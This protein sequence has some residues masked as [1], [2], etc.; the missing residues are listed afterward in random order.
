MP[1]V[2]LN[3]E[4]VRICSICRKDESC[5]DVVFGYDHRPRDKKKAKCDKCLAE[6]HRERRK[7]PVLNASARAACRKW[8]RNNPDKANAK[9]RRYQ[10]KD[11][12]ANA[13]RRRKYRDKTDDVAI[14]HERKKNAIPKWADTKAIN[15]KYAE[16]KLLTE[17]F[18]IPFHVDHIVPIHGKCWDRGSPFYGKQVV[19]GLHTHDNLEVVVGR[20]NLKKG[21]SWN[22]LEEQI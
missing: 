3:G 20:D 1:F 15:A 2:E 13:A 11:L 18:G 19:S 17:T 22:P 21:S 14:R 16:A 5:D 8:A 6:Q 12:D 10:L 4:R 9:T 7:D